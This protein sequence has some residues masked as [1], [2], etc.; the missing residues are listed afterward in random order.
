MIVGLNPCVSGQLLS[1]GAGDTSS[2]QE[3]Q[4]MKEDLLMGGPGVLPMKKRGT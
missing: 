1:R 4:S 2:S 3:D